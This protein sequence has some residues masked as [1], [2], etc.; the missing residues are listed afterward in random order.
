MAGTAACRRLKT[1]DTQGLIE[2]F[3][4]AGK[5][6][7]EAGKQKQ[8]ALAFREKGKLSAIALAD[9]VSG[10]R[11]GGEGAR[12]CADAAADLLLQKGRMLTSCGGQEA[13]EFITSHV[14]HEQRNLALRHSL[15]AT[16]YACTLAAVFCDRR[17]EKLLFCSLGDSMILAVRRGQCEILVLPPDSTDGCCV[18]MTE[19]AERGMQTGIIDLRGVEAVYIL[20]D[21]AWEALFEGGSLT[22]DARTILQ[23]RWYEDLREYLQRQNCEDDYSFISIELKPT[24]GRSAA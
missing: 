7:R 19:H 24:A 3:S 23:N 22:A 10:C 8:D 17:A 2:T 13:A 5:R 16:E 6:H 11:C 20:S 15:P 18:T 14:V 4:A 12:L 21:G 9:G 1:E